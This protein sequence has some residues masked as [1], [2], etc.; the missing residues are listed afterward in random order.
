MKILLTIIY[1]LTT[2][3]GMIFM[4]LGG[5]SLGFTIK[6]GIDFKIGGLTLIGF[7][8]YA[9]S[10]LLWQR[11]LVTFDLSYIVPITTGIAQILILIIGVSIFKENINIYNIVGV[12]LIIVGVLLISLKRL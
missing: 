4:K 5:N 1:L 9:V 2:T 7:I 3:A 10:F 12:L 11:L 8:L 6:E